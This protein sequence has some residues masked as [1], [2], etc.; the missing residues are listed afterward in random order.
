[1]QSASDR[2]WN[3]GILALAGAAA[4]TFSANAQAILPAGDYRT[5][6]ADVTN[7]GIAVVE[8]QCGALERPSIPQSFQT[9][10]EVRSAQ[11]QRDAFADR[12]SR[13][14]SCVTTFINSYRRPGADANSKA[15]DQAAC[16]HA[17]AQNQATEL[18]CQVGFA[19]IDFSN[20]TMVDQS[21]EPW[22]GECFPTVAPEQG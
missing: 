5:C 10:T 18:V 12:V 4:L 17:W 14:G 7:Q 11:A 9:L 19:C 6:P 8:T 1:M 22:S 13:Y 16:A 21:L 2:Q 3:R 15:P 20:R